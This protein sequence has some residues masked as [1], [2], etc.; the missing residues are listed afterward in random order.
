[1]EHN[2]LQ[3]MWLVWM[4]QQSKT[5]LTAAKWLANDCDLQVTGNARRTLF[6]VTRYRGTAGASE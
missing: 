3:T 1:L 6:H 5:R 4:Q 2:L